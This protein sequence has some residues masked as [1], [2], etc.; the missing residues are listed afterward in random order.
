MIGKQT[1]IGTSN[2][3]GADQTDSSTYGYIWTLHQ[4]KNSP[5]FILFYLINKKIKLIAER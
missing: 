5:I 4:Q 3:N 1:D 2:G